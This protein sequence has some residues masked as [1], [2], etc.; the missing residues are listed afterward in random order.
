MNENRN[1]EHKIAIVTGGASGL[2]YAIAEKFVQEDIRTII[3]GRNEEKLKAAKEKLGSLCAAISFDLTELGQIPALVE[4]IHRE[5]GKIDILV[6]NAGINQKKAFTEVTDEDFQRILLTNLTAVFALSREVAKV[7]IPQGSG[8]IVNI[9]SM[10]AQYGIPKVISYSAAK[11]G[12]EGMTRAMAVDLSPLGIRVNCVAPGFI[13]TDMSA[14]AFDSEPERR[15]K[16]LSRTPMGKLG[17]PADVAGA[18]Y[19]Y[20]TAGAKYVTGTILPVD[21]GNSIGF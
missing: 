10:A 4:S 11:T 2:G 12:V 3:I 8:A 17:E 15:N 9:S 19:F 16:V 13:A 5:F 20:A 7:M 6:N 18:V 21:G 14:K 1:P